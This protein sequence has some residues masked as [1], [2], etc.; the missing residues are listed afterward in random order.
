MC[1]RKDPSAAEIFTVGVIRG[2][3]QL[4]MAVV[5]FLFLLIRGLGMIELTS[6]PAWAHKRRSEALPK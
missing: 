6:R 2:A 1:E 5:A 3:I 4:C